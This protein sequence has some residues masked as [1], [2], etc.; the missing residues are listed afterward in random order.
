MVKPDL[1]IKVEDDRNTDTKIYLYA[2][3]DEMKQ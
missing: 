1:K 2:G 3:G